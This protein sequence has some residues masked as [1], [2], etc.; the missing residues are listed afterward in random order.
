MS[1][2][3]NSP[4]C[5]TRPVTFVLTASFPFCCT[6]SQDRDDAPKVAPSYATRASL[7]SLLLSTTSDRAFRCFLIWLPAGPYTTLEARVA[8][9]VDRPRFRGYAS[10]EWARPWTLSNERPRSRRAPSHPV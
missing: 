5:V 7:K 6:R 2:C 10:T 8:T 3:F 1:V 4:P 9:A